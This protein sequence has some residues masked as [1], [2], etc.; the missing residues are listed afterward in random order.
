MEKKMIDVIVIGAGISG[1]SASVRLSE[2]AINHIILEGR[3]RTGGRIYG[4]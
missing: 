1:M 3:D 4:R 2:A